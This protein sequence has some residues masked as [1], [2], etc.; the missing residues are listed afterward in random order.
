MCV[1]Y[2]ARWK[3]GR[4]AILKR[5]S[6]DTME[7]LME[8]DVATITRLV[9]DIVLKGKEDGLFEKLKETPTLALCLAEYDPKN[10]GVIISMS[11]NATLLMTSNSRSLS[12]NA[13]RP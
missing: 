1:Q 5:M 6:M 12:K 4:V 13:T 9:R 7:R 3:R 10:V 2:T 8:H 11:E